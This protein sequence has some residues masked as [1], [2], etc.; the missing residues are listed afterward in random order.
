MDV[1]FDAQLKSDKAFFPFFFKVHFMDFLVYLSFVFYVIIKP[2]LH[3]LLNWRRTMRC[4][5]NCPKDHQ[6]N[7]WETNS[8]DTR[9]IRATIKKRITRNNVMSPILQI[10]K[11]RR[12]EDIL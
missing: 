4:L 11:M 1:L 12:V 2:Y 8:V 9:R 10:L 3:R 5:P 6:G 7:Q